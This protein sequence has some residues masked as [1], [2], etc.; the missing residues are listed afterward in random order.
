MHKDEVAASLGRAFG[1]NPRQKAIRNSV[2]RI[3]R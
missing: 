2:M 1:Y 3:L